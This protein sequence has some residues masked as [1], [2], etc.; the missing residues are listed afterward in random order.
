MRFVSVS[1][2]LHEYWQNIWCIWNDVEGISRG[3]VYLERMIH[4]C[5]GGGE[6]QPGWNKNLQ[7]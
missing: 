3:V 6:T 7:S 5:C 2:F 1:F 4:V